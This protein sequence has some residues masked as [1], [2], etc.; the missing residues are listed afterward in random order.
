MSKK[1]TKEELERMINS[2]DCVDR[3]EVA[4]QGYGL[5]KLINDECEYVR[6]AVAEQGYGLDKLI[7]DK[8]PFVRASSLSKV[9]DW[10]FFVMTRMIVFDT[11]LGITINR[12]N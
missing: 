11:L 3:L 5:D 1:Y 8:D 9:M 12:R 4:G 2:S 10:I 6:A 7:D